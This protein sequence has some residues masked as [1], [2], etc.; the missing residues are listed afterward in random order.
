MPSIAIHPDKIRAYL[1]TD[2][3]IDFGTTPVV[4]R[5]GVRSEP[6]A[7]LFDS[8][9]VDC[10]AFLT[11][12]NPMGVPQSDVANSADHARL[13]ERLA[14]EARN[15]LPGAG[16]DPTGSWQPEKSVFALGLPLDAAR[17]IGSEFSQDAIV[18]VGHDAVPELILLR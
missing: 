5:I 14:K 3:R 8:Q 6:L 13:E 10:G 1:T 16:C 12:W 17:R 9:G 11:A 7:R 15:S 4:L 2:Y 18:W